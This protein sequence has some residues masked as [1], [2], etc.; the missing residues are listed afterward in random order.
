[1]EEKDKTP[2]SSGAPEG[3]APVDSAS[4]KSDKSPE[5]LMAQ[6]NAPADSLE[7]GP[8]TSSV[9]AMADDSTT[10]A[11]AKAAPKKPQTKGIRNILSKVNIYLVLF[12]LLLVLAGASFAVFYFMNKRES[13]IRLESTE[14][15]EEALEEL[16]TS[17]AIVGD[18]RQILTIESNA[19]ITGKVVMRDTLD[20]AGGLRVGGPISV[21]SIST[22]GD[23]NFGSLATNDFQAAGNGSFGGLLDVAGALAVGNN[24]TVAGDITGG[25]KLDIE[26]QA[27]IG[28]N[29]NVNGTVSALGINFDSISV[30]HINISGGQ[31]S[32]G[33][34]GAAGG[35]ATASISGTDTAGTATIN[36]GGG[37]GTGIIGTITFNSSFSKAPYPVLTPNGSGCAN[38]AYYVTNI[39]ST[40]FSIASATAPPAGAT[41]RF[42]YMVIN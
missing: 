41:C 22:V 32:I 12:I 7:G 38:I 25:G 5:D 18:P 40:S 36:T 34:S 23:G 24:L 31:P 10:D 37:T 8:K 39:S 20:I 4:Q 11:A 26:G 1:M 14:L 42:N 6:V 29:L 30:N 19:V 2:E 27:T 3:N 33:V 13:N 15:T 35:G 16:K 28:G 21:P 17:D 9:D